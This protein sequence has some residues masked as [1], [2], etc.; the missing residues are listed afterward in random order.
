MVFTGKS[1]ISCVVKQL[2]VLCEISLVHRMK[3]TRLTFEYFLI[4]YL[5]FDEHFCYVYTNY[6]FV[7]LR[8]YTVHKGT[9]HPDA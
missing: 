2:S 8:S 4:V 5:T 3:I 6:F 9:L 7:K 1:Y